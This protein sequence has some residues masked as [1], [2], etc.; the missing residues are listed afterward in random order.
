MNCEELRQRW[1]KDGYLVIDNIVD[2]QELSKLKQRMNQLIDEVPN[3]E[4]TSIFST[5]KQE[6]KRDE[7]FLSSGDKIRFFMEEKVEIKDDQ[8]ITPK[9]SAI[10]K[11]AHALHELDPVFKKFTL[12]PTH[13]KIAKEVLGYTDPVICQSMYILKP[14]KIGG[15]VPVHQ[16]STY[17]FTTPESVCGMW[18]PIDD[19]Y[20][21]NACLWV[22]PGS[23]KGPLRTRY[24]L[25]GNTTTHIPPFDA[26]QTPYPDNKEFVPLEVKKGGVVILQGR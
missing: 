20:V 23:H 25:K 12:S 3:S 21:G 9:H 16:D 8:L 13:V 4:L 15:A 2:H 5:G 6:Y 14:P 17:L 19:A 11:V 22:A 7:Y 10:N 18:F 24:I 26:L 1:E